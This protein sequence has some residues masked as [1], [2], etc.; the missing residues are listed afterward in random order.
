MDP[1]FPV[2]TYQFKQ[3]G[4]A[5]AF[6]SCCVGLLRNVSTDNCVMQDVGLHGNSDV[7]SHDCGEWNLHI[8]KQC[9]SAD[10]LLGAIQ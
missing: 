10:Q 2:S 8:P 7:I 9:T 1:P 5:T 6:M 4:R 3:W